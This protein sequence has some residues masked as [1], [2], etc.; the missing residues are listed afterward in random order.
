MQLECKRYLTKP[1]S[2]PVLLLSFSGVSN[3]LFLIMKKL[4]QY[5]KTQKPHP[6]IKSPAQI[7]IYSIFI[8]LKYSKLIHR[9]AL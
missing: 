9:F 6:F 4:N 8:R 3:C 5:L 7:F 2:V 1:Y